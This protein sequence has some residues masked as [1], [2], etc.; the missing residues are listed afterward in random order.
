[1]TAIE[2][3]SLCVSV[4]LGAVGLCCLSLWRR[5]DDLVF[6]HFAIVC[7][8]GANGAGKSTCMK[9]LTTY[10]YPS[11]G[12]AEVGGVAAA[13]FAPVVMGLI[14]W[15]FTG[16]KRSRAIGAWASVNGLGQAIGD[17]QLQVAQAA[18]SFPNTAIT[19]SASSR[20]SKHINTALIAA[21]DS[22]QGKLRRGTTALAQAPGAGW[23]MLHA[24]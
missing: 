23:G 11:R 6:R 15:L 17:L 21:N 18:I 22:D 14:Q 1:M 12:T 16:E 3:F 8:I 19:R 24:T 2:A 4:A 13:P 7:L 9:I 10:L 5:L 20:C